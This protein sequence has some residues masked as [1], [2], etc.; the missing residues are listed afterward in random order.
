MKTEIIIITDTSG[1]MAF[2]MEDATG[3]I[4]SFIEEQK[5]VPG[6]ARVSIFTFDSHVHQV[7]D[8]VDVASV[9]PI[10]LHAN[11]MTAL[12]DAIGTALDKCGKRIA[13]QKWAD[14][15]IV[16]ITT[17]GQENSSR[18]YTGERVREMV[19]HAEDNGW[20][21]IFAAA[22]QDAFASA[23]SVGI[24]CGVATPYQA[25]AKGTETLYATMSASVTSLRGGG[26][27]VQGA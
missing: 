15:V 9:K 5:K 25:S 10:V 4:N 8:A 7:L 20:K 2:L 22:N 14:Q 1:S 16:M 19:K 13:E 23:Q 18:E 11:G 21:F 24:T 12:H 3:G 27:P 6:E 17:D 26:T